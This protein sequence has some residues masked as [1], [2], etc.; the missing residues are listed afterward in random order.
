M[1]ETIRQVTRRRWQP[2][3]TNVLELSFMAAGPTEL[4]RQFSE[5]QRLREFSPATVRRRMVTLR[6]FAAFVAPSSLS[7]ATTDDAQEFLKK[8][9]APRTRHAYRSDLSAF[10]TW[11][12]RRSLIETNPMLLIDAI[13]IP[14]TLPRPVPA[15]LVPSLVAMAPEQDLRLMVAFAAYAGLRV[16]EIASICAEDIDLVNGLVQVRQGKGLKD[17]VVPLHPVLRSL[18]SGRMPKAGRLFHLQSDT[19]GRKIATYLRESGVDASAHKLRATFATELAEMARGN[20]VLVQRLLGHSSPDT[21]ML[22][23]GWLGGEAGDTVASM[24]DQAG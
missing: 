15:G 8:F 23:V 11:A 13:R 14:K 10:Y 18:L 7:Q 24:Y 9:P 19:I 17:R 16:A 12:V 5:Y 21:T 3:V 1:T 22:Y 20:I 2:D 4:E 6:Q